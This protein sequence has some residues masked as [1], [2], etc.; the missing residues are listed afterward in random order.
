[1]GQFDKRLSDED[2]VVAVQM[3]DSGWRLR[4]TARH[5]GIGFNTLA[6]R[7]RRYRDRNP[8]PPPL[9]APPESVP[10]I[11]PEIL[12]GKI[13]AP[14]RSERSRHRR[15]SNGGGRI[16]GVIR[17]GGDGEGNGWAASP[18]SATE[19]APGWWLTEKEHARTMIACEK[20]DPDGREVDFRRV[21]REQA[22]I[23]VEQYGYRA[24][25]AG[26]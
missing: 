12:P 17:L 6:E 10:M 14:F 9:P 18:R 16:L 23:L 1:M 22:V 21:P 11:A 2:L 26:S 25:P 20:R 4:A 5:F 3:L 8:A 15:G 24:L 13:P 19:S 7:A